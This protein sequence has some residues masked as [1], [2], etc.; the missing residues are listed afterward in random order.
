M[1]KFSTSLRARFRDRINKL[2]SSQ[3]YFYLKQMV[4]NNVKGIY[5]NNIMIIRGFEY[6]LDISQLKNIGK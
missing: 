3:L 2:R 4:I 1:G 6:N 5:M